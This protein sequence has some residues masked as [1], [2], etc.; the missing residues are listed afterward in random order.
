MISSKKDDI[1]KLT[2][3][4]DTLNICGIDWHLVFWQNSKTYHTFYIHFEKATSWGFII[5][6]ILSIYLI[7][8]PEINL[9]WQNTMARMVCF[10]AFYVL[11]FTIV[12]LFLS[13]LLL[14]NYASIV[15]LAYHKAVI[16]DLQE[17]EGQMP[18]NQRIFRTKG[19]P[20]ASLAFK[21]A[22]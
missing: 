15:D 7:N 9:I 17:R 14:N 6:L 22:Q 13:S 12:S 11:R 18:W 21:L 3:N 2:L 4:L 1:H 10:Y 19:M 16:F 20:D 5:F 8:W